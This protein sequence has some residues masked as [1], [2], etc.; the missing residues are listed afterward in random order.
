MTSTDIF[1]AAQKI[2]DALGGFSE[3]EVRKAI[4]MSLIAVDMTNILIDP[5]DISIKSCT[6]PTP[7]D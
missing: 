6:P 1:E 3:S 2:V 7:L 5:N 4:L